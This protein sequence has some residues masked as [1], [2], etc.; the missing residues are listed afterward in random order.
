MNAKDEVKDPAALIQAA[1]IAQEDPGNLW[2]QIA[3]YFDHQRGLVEPREVD[4]KA[5][6]GD[7]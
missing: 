4:K 1:R 6:K 5:P 3:D 7:Y 2:A